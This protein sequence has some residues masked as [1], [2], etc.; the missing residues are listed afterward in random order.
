MTNET[1]LQ[2]Q[3]Q[4]P[5]GPSVQAIIK[6]EEDVLQCV[7]GVFKTGIH[8]GRVP[9]VKGDFLWQAGANTLL[10]RFGLKADVQLEK[11]THEEHFI[12]YVARAK[13][14]HGEKVVAECLGS[15]NSRE[16]KYVRKG[17]EVWDLDNTLLK[18]AQKRAKVGAVDQLFGVNAL[19]DQME[20][21]SSGSK[22]LMATGE[23]NPFTP[24]EESHTEADLR[25]AAEEAKTEEEKNAV[26]ANIDACFKAGKIT[27]NVAEHLA[28]DLGS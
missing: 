24:H 15:A 19:I 12:H 11:A 2:K 16:K 1:G 5:S 7:R 6:R 21:G 4:G 3:E 13:I 23:G 18:M 17:G 14:L 20:N 8:Y 10:S 9:G 27:R 25:Q 22:P 26:R 28:M